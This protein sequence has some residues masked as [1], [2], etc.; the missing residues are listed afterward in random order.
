MFTFRFTTFSK[1][2]KNQIVFPLQIVAPEHWLCD[3]CSEQAECNQGVCVCK[4]G[5]NGDGIECAYNCPDD[6]V[7][8]IDRCEPINSNS[9]EDEEGKKQSLEFNT[10]KCM[11]LTHYFSDTAILLQR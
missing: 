10:I 6:Y 8:N 2:E 1:N 9:E 4:N 7:W 3:Q 11:I 5:W